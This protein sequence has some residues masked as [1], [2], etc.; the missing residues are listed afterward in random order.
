MTIM[1]FYSRFYFPSFAIN[2]RPSVSNFTRTH[3][4]GVL[5]KI[6]FI[7]HG[8]SSWRTPKLSLYTMPSRP[9]TLIPS[10]S[11]S[12]A[13]SLSHSLTGMCNI[14]HETFICVFTTQHNIPKLFP[15]TRH[16]MQKKVMHSHP[17]LPN[18]SQC[19]KKNVIWCLFCLWTLKNQI[20][21][22]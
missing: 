20:N 8:L 12:L 7:F 16:R 18:G 2:E 5:I 6:A 10:P 1:F 4:D 11:R 3:Y 22:F 17:D 19:E 21:K 14:S 9:R 15:L 13:L